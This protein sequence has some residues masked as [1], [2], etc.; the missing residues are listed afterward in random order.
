M[1]SFRRSFLRS[2]G[3]ASLLLSTA[4]VSGCSAESDATESATSEQTTV[5][6]PPQFVLLAFDGSLNNDFWDES[7]AFAQDANV[8]LTYF[9]SGTY[10]IPNGKKRLYV[11]PH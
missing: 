2:L 7:R 11:G 3:A 5:A 6:R 10:F 4:A 8:K 9:I 1:L